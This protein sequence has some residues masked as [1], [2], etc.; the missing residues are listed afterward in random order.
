MRLNSW[1]NWFG[2]PVI[3]LNAATD[4]WESGFMVRLCQAL[5]AGEQ[6]CAIY[7]IFA[8]NT[9]GIAQI[10]LFFQIGTRSIFIQ[11]T[12]KSHLTGFWRLI[13]R[14]R[15]WCLQPWGFS[16]LTHV[17]GLYKIVRLAK[18]AQFEDFTDR[19]PYWVSF[20]WPDTNRSPIWTP[21]DIGYFD[22]IVVYK[23]GS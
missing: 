10:S 6:R 23:S 5:M 17:S 15:T 14:H 19:S 11:H 8:L 4:S 2:H 12:R 13:T 3:R 21:I 20:H 16:N 1:R 18:W 9:R 7:Q 22:R